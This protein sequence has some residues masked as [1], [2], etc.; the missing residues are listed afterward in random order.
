MFQKSFFTLE[1]NIC[2]SIIEDDKGIYEKLSMN[3][4]NIENNKNIIIIKISLWNT[5]NEKLVLIVINLLNI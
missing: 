5:S 1:K 2:R 3:L 4:K